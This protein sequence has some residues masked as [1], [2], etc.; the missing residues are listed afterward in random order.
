MRKFPLD[1]RSAHTT[2]LNCVA[3]TKH[4]SLATAAENFQMATSFLVSL[5]LPTRPTDKVV[6]MRLGAFR[7]SR[8]TTPRYYYVVVVVGTIH[9]TISRL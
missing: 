9:Q 7:E 6:V 3:S 5:S 8:D 1:S 4:A 2:T